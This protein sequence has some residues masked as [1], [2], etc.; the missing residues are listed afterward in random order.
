MQ[1]VQS[2]RHFLA[3]AS[4]AS[5]TGVFGARRSFADEGPLETTTVRLPFNSNIC[6]APQFVAEE[7]LRAD[8]FTEVR[9]V[10]SS[11]G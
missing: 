3:S 8:G 6:L 10:R 11:G 2:R 1:I 7:L 5:A 9:Y 4:L